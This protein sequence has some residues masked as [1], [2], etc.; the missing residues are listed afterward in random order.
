VV[1]VIRTSRVSTASAS[2]T[3]QIDRSFVS[4]VDEDRVTQAIA[5]AMIDMARAPDLEV[6]AEG[7]VRERQA[8]LL[9]DLG[10]V[11]AQGYLFGRPRHPTLDR[12]G[13]A[14]VAESLGVPQ[15]PCYM[16]TNRG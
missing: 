4:V 11:S 14:P 6:V 16:L 1:R 12:P 3:L 5:R 8:D 2:Q 7:V 10:C 13:L 9:R 15:E